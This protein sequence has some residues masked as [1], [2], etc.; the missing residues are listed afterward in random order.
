MGKKAT[1]YYANGALIHRDARDLSKQFIA[2]D[3]ITGKPVVLRRPQDFKPSHHIRI[4]EAAQE[5]AV[6]VAAEPVVLGDVK[7]TDELLNGRKWVDLN[8]EEKVLYKQLK[9]NG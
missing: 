8:K 6:E 1:P 2:I 4:Q 9:D 5:V 7:T 3:K